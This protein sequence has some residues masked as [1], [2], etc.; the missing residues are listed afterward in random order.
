MIS[1]VYESRHSSIHTL[2]GEIDKHVSLWEENTRLT[3]SNFWLQLF[4]TF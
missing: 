3:D 1:K 4:N 2:F